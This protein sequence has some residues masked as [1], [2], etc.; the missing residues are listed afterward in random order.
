LI[1]TQELILFARKEVADHA[2]I[3]ECDLQALRGIPSDQCEAFCSEVHPAE[4][5]NVSKFIAEL[6]D[7]KFRRVLRLR[8]SL[9]HADFALCQPLT[10]AEM[11]TAFMHRYQAQLRAQALALEAA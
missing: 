10:D 7:E 8:F 6:R 2:T 1:K 5:N 9:K 4:R 11:L 3:F